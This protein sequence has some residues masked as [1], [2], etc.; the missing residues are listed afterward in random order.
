MSAIQ[1]LVAIALLTAPPDAPLGTDEVNMVDA[2]CPTLQQLAIQL[3]ILDPRE[4]KYILNRSEDYVSDLKLLRRRYQDLAEAPYAQDS[5][6]F[7]DRNLINELLSF[8]RSFRQNLDSR[9]ATETVRLWE[10]R[11]ALQETDRLYQ[12]WDTL[13][14][15]RC[16]YYYV[17]VRRQALKKLRELIGDEAYFTGIMPPFVPV[18]RFHPID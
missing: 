2:V 7:P 14:D 18:W 4:V 5:Q 3:E 15:A 11:E 16:D 13:R 10:V 6:R 1:I 17:T 12:A 8:N 9:Q